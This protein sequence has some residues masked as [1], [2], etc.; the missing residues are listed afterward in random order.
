MPARYDLDAKIHKLL[1]LIVIYGER[2]F[3]KRDFVNR[4][5]AKTLFPHATLSRQNKGN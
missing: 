2:F 1:F 5:A 3:F 4:W